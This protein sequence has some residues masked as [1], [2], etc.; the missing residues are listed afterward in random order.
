MSTEIGRPSG[1]LAGPERSTHRVP[2]A[3]P[4]VL[5]ELEVLVTARLAF[6]WFRLASAII[7]AWP[8][9]RRPSPEGR[10]RPAAAR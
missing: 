2:A 1:S 3:L 5:E 8:G 7:T 6:P 4:E 9:G 10:R